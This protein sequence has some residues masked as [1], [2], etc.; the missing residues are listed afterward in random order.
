MGLE[1]RK[2]VVLIFIHF[3]LGQA[4]PIFFRLDVPLWSMNSVGLVAVVSLKSVTPG[5]TSKMSIQS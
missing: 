3:G 5:V 1:R 2:Q 4:K